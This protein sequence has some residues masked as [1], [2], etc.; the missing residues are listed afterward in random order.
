MRAL[1]VAAAIACA[2]MV[3]QSVA[4][5][6]ASRGAESSDASADGDGTLAG[7]TDSSDTG[8]SSSSSSSGAGGSS[9]GDAGG[10]L[11]DARADPNLHC[12]PTGG[13]FAGE[14]LGSCNLCTDD[15]STFAGAPAGTCNGMPCG[16]GC[17]C[18][19]AFGLRCFCPDLQ[20]QTE[21]GSIRYCIALS[22]GGI[23]CD[24]ACQCADPAHGAC[25]C[26]VDAGAD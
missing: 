13:S 2:F 10:A 1:A 26:L 17:G 3:A 9:G 19:K 15:A 22:C 14:G 6:S 8:S 21:D 16:G 7:D 18:D 23:V 20:A 24:P 25:V 11:V 5:S 12:S 4:C